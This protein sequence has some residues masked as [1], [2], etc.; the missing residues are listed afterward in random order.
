MEDI[1]EEEKKR[2]KLMAKCEYGNKV[3]FLKF[4]PIFIRFSFF[5]WEVGMKGGKK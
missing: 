4:L 1:G 2:R 5:G 3:E